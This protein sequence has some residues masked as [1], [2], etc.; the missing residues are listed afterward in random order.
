M[1]GRCFLLYITP[2]HPT[3]PPRKHKTSVYIYWERL[4][5]VSLFVTDLSVV[6]YRNTH[7]KKP[8]VD[9]RNPVTN[10]MEQSF[11]EREGLLSCSQQS[12]NGI[13]PEPDESNVHH[14]T[15]PC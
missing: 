4:G 5:E 13:H 14:Q 3:P 7:D 15:I 12:A 2:S 6:T 11:I 8:V 10:C 9:F 1:L